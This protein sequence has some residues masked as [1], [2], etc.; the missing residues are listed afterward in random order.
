MARESEDNK[1]DLEEANGGRDSED[2]L[3]GECPES[4]W[5]ERRSASNCR[6][7]GV[8][9]AISAKGTLPDKN[10]KTNTTTTMGPLTNFAC[11]TFEHLQLIFT[12]IFFHIILRILQL[13]LGCFQLNMN[14]K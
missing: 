2:W 7:N 5:L 8:N 12:E 4:N 1:K 6:R 13:F 11:L 3:E 14:E 10:L 9:L